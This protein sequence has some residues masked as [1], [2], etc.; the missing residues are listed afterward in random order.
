MG[1]KVS[2][3]QM[4]FMLDDYLYLIASTSKAVN[5]LRKARGASRSGTPSPWPITR[6]ICSPKREPAA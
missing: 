6:E 4:L 1:I 3:S 5:I 2:F